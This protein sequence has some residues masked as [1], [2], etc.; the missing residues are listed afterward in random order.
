M[1]Q[2]IGLVGHYSSRRCFTKRILA[3]QRS[4]VVGEPVLT[5]ASFSFTQRAKF[6]VSYP[7]L[8]NE[9]EVEA[10]RS[11]SSETRGNGA[12]TRAILFDSR[13][14]KA[15]LRPVCGVEGEYGPQEPTLSQVPANDEI[16]V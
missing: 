1:G 16:T 11:N 4:P 10:T 5:Q 7:R 13:E 3:Q 6:L 15:A 9:E 2:Y 12:G 14:S 8:T